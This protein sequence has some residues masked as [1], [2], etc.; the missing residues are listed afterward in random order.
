MCETTRV[1]Q[2]N[3]HIIWWY[4]CYGRT[5]GAGPSGT[6]PLVQLSRDSLALGLFLSVF[7]SKWGQFLPQTVQPEHHLESKSARLTQGTVTA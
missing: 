7:I 3:T 6:L 2:Q 5:H 4:H 1:L